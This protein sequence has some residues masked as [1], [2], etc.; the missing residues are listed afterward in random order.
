M[1]IQPKS[2]Q[3]SQPQQGQASKQAD[4]SQPD[5]AAAQPVKQQAWNQNQQA[6]QKANT[7]VNQGQQGLK[8]QAHTSK[9]PMDDEAS[10][11]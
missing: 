2:G 8:D 11:K 1:A 5:K 9:M 3:Q 10:K 4:H 6:G 7:Q